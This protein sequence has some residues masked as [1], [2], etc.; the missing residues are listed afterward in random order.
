MI[1]LHAKSP[2]CRASVS[3]FGNRRRRCDQC[4]HTWSIRVKKRGRKCI[5]VHAR[6]AAFAEASHESLRHKASRTSRGRELIRRRHA[7]TMEQL[8]ARPTRLLPKGPYICVIDG[9]VLFFQK[10]P[11]VTYL[12]L[13]RPVQGTIAHVMEPYFEPGA[14][15]IRGW[16]RAFASLPEAVTQRIQAVVCDG[17]LGFDRY[18][19][20]QGWILQRCHVHI[21]RQLQRILGTRRS[22]VRAKQLRLKAFR[23]VRTILADPD[24]G[25]VAAGVRQLAAL[26][27]GDACP[28]RF[29]LKVRGFLNAYRSFRSYLLYPDIYLPTTTNSAEH[30]CSKLTELVRRT[31]SFRNPEAYQRWVKVYLKLHPTVQCKGKVS[32]E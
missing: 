23:L 6:A 11:W 32:T 1:K 10:K 28:H 4:H 30:L 21:L 9:F 17:I 31:R 14:E 19:Q 29:G 18:T 24:E 15:T 3:R 13:V 12:I 7:H 26:A 2:C 5:R 22:N 25:V 8:L 27:Y 16:E 20:V